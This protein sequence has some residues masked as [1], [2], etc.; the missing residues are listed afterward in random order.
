MEEYFIQQKAFS[1]NAR[2]LIQD[3]KGNTLYLLVSSNEKYGIV[4]HLYNLNGTILGSTRQVNKFI[5]KRFFLYQNYEKIATMQKI[6]YFKKNQYFLSK[7]N[8]IAG[9]NFF[10]HNYK[11]KHGNKIIM[12]VH[13]A[14]LFKGDFYSLSISEKE[15]AI[16]A[17]LIAAILDY[18][19]ANLSSTKRNQ[20]SFKP[21]LGIDYSFM[22]KNNGHRKLSVQKHR[23]EKPLIPN[24]GFSPLGDFIPVPKTPVALKQLTSSPQ[25]T[26]TSRHMLEE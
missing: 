15:N 19:L 22:S 6:P 5:K 7:L 3:E 2:T 13:K 8:W 24:R 9:G 12:E 26:S 14:Y 20:S 25:I 10:E 17:I 18:W 23:S 4:I 16:P 21:A 11:V 1:S